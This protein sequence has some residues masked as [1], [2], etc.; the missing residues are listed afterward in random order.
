V[1]RDGDQ[2]LYLNELRHHKGTAL[3]L[4][5]P[6]DHPDLL[7]ARALLGETGIQI[8]VDYRGE[9]VVGTARKIP[10]SPWVMLAELDEAELLTPLRRMTLTVSIAVVAALLAALLGVTLLW[11]HWIAA[12]LQSQLVVEQ[13][14]SRLAKRLD[15]LISASPT[16]LYAADISELHH[17]HFHQREYHP[18]DR[19][20]T[21]RVHRRSRSL[22]DETYPSR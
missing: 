19:L 22:L 6:L 14:R 4:L 7:A 21:R 5:L 20:R 15:F 16:A 11:R 3:A 9:R 10:D 17:H 2:V 12:L 8:G 13:A 18:L 1:R